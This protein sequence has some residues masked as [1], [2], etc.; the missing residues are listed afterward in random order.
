MFKC[1]SYFL[2]Y[3]FFPFIFYWVYTATIVALKASA[4]KTTISLTFM[5]SN[6]NMTHMTNMLLAIKKAQK[7]L[8]VVHPIHSAHTYQ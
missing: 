7:N 6:Q 4:Y 3:T 8:F 2:N 1:Y 5:S